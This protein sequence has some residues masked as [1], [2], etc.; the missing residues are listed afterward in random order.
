MLFLSPFYCFKRDSEVKGRQTSLIR[1]CQSEQVNVGQLALTRDVI[2]AKAPALTYAD[3]I[4]PEY[5]LALRTEGLQMRRRIFCGGGLTWI[6]WVGQ[7]SNELVLRMRTCRPSILTI[8]PNH[9]CAVHDG[10]EQGQTAQSVHSRR[11]RA[12]MRLGFVAKQIHYL[13][14]DESS[15]SSLGTSALH[16]ACAALSRGTSALRASSESTRPAVVPRLAA[17]SLAI[18]STSSSISNVV[19][20]YLASRINHQ[21]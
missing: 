11:G 19:R 4:W 18:S 9:L 3:G 13:R 20:I 6:R 1:Y 10:H 15:I 8:A 2:P 17:S 5:I 14:C 16:Y 7:Y 21:M 12:T